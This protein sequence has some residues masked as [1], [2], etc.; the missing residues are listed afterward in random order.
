MLVKVVRAFDLTKCVKDQVLLGVRNI[1]SAS[2]S[3]VVLDLLA[4]SF[5][6]PELFCLFFVEANSLAV[7]INL[8]DI[9][10]V[11]FLEVLA[12]L[13]TGERANVNHKLARDGEWTAARFIYG[14]YF[15]IQSYI[16]ASRDFSA[17]CR[18]GNK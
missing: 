4:A 7:Y 14:N 5:L 8:P 10:I 11:L 9:K 16:E 12:E 15:P 18:L 17:A 13:F 1:D 2:L 6:N 3:H